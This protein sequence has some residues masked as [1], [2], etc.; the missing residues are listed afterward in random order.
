MSNVNG[1]LDAVT[2]QFVIEQPMVTVVGGMAYAPY[3]S[4]SLPI[5]LPAEHPYLAKL[6]DG[7][8]DTIE[9]DKDGNV[10]LVARVMR[11][12]LNKFVNAQRFECIDEY[13]TKNAG[14]RVSGFR[15]NN[16]NPPNSRS[17]MCSSLPS[18]NDS[19]NTAKIG[20]DWI[21]GLLCR[22]S[23]DDLNVTDGD[24]VATRIKKFNTYAQN[25]VDVQ[26]Y[27]AL[28]NPVA[29][30]LGK[31][32]VPSLPETISNVW[33]DAELTTDMSMTYKQDVNAVIAGLTAQIASLKGTA[34]EPPEVTDPTIE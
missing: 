22:Y 25:K 10:S 29:Y 7:T 2:K 28:S 15:I 32:T 33:I 16:T 5:T 13:E 3:I 20:I 1:A 17:T 21:D 23:W 34:D 19:W 4:Q 27:Y 11:T 6:P 14:L 8:A 24:T 9:V 18:L 31:L 30:S 26:M 12:S